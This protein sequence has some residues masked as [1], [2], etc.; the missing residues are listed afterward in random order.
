M[1]FLPGIRFSLDFVTNTGVAWGLFPGFPSL[2]LV[3]RLAVIGALLVYFV[4]NR[5]RPFPLTLILAGA[6]GNS[7]DLICYRHVIDFLH[8]WFFNWSFP[9]FN[10]A[11]SYITIGAILLFLFPRKKHVNV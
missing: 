4:R 6:V 7:I 9:V 8:F 2:L 11:D 3:F 5:E 10:F 1:F